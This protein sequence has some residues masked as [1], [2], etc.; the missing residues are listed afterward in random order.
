MN[1]YSTFVRRESDVRESCVI[2]LGDIN[3][4]YLCS[5][6]QSESI[7][8]D[9]CHERFEIAFFKSASGTVVVEGKQYNLEAGSLILINPFAYHRIEQNHEGYLEAWSV[10]FSKSS[11]SSSVITDTRLYPL[12]YPDSNAP[13]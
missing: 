8:G 11:L 5:D 10:L 6:H 4:R 1:T 12:K 13:P 9:F 2:S 3:V 7:Q